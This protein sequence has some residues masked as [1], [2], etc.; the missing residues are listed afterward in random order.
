MNIRVAR[1]ALL[2][3]ALALSGLTDKGAA[4]QDQGY[5]PLAYARTRGDRVDNLEAVIPSQCYTKTEGISNPCWTCHTTSNSI[6]AMHDQG[7]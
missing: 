1:T 5:D 4:A 6:N 3:G 2:L 7:L